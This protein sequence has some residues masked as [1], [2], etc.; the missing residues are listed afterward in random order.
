[1][2][3]RSNWLIMSSLYVLIF[4]LL[5]P[6][7]IEIWVFKSPTVHLSIAKF[8]LTRGGKIERQDHIDGI[9]NVSKEYPWLFHF[10]YTLAFLNVYILTFYACS[11]SDDISK[12]C[13]SSY[14]HND[15]QMHLIQIDWKISNS[16]WIHI[17]YTWQPGCHAN[18]F[19]YLVKGQFEG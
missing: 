14:F 16:L 6:S 11:F 18:H 7:L 15:V 3:I 10:K 8:I 5:V 19:F 1:M 12:K 4:C 17:N 9:T 2:S 13:V